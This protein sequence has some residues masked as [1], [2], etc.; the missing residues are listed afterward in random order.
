MNLAKVL[1]LSLASLAA[2]LLT[3]ICYGGTW[4]GLRTSGPGTTGWQPL[5]CQ[6]GSGWRSCEMP[7]NIALS[8][9]P[10]SLVAIGQQATITATVTDYYGVAIASAVLN[11]K[12]TDGTISPAQTATNASGQ[13]SIT[14]TSSHTLG[15]AT[16]S[17]ETV[18][19]DGIGSIWVP[20]IDK[21]VATTSTYTGWSNSGGVYSCGAWSPDASTVPSGTGFW[22]STNCWQTQ[23]RYRQDREVSVVT[24]AIRNVGGLVAEYQAVVVTISQFAVGTLVIAPVCTY[25]GMGGGGFANSTLWAAIIWGATTADITYH[26]Y[27]SG[28]TGITVTV[29][30]A[31][32]S[33]AGVTAAY[34][35]Q[36]YTVG[37]LAAVNPLGGNAGN[38]RNLYPACA[39]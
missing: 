21:W 36:T 29:P 15:G 9:N 12:T 20:Y 22:Q 7:V 1:K 23:V 19:K 18:E 39:Q 8:A 17:A 16:V 2:L 10:N 27:V 31:N 24:G 13:S 26:L 33:G 35:G 37:G 34:N 32:Q 3:S 25:V 14:L 6:N 5:I 11:W 28:D 30:Y 38:V 4:S